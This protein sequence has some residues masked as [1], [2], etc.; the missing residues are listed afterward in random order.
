MIQLQCEAGTESWSRS[1]LGRELQ[2][3]VSHS[4]HHFALI[5]LLLANDGPVLPREFGVAPSTL[6]HQG[7][8]R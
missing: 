1:T 4:V 8:L 7:A 3:L 2:F 5:K 6:S